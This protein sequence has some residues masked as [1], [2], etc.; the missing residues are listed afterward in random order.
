MKP[1]LRAALS[2][3]MLTCWTCSSSDLATRHISGIV[4]IQAEPDAD[5]T[6]VTLPAV[7][8]EA[9][10]VYPRAPFEQ[11][12]EGEVLVRALVSSQ[13]KVV[14]TEVLSSLDRLLDQSAVHCVERSSYS[15]PLRNGVPV[16]MSVRITCRFRLDDPSNLK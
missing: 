3:A 14:S 8:R 4:L 15:A 13:G 7:V 1:I 11:G 6:G 12:I 16:D 10:L 9:R 2:A 5:T